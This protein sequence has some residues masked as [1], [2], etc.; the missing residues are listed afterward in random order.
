[1][2]EAIILGS[3]T[4]N[5]V[6][7]LGTTYTDEYLA[8]P[9]NHRTRASI[10]FKGPTGN[11]LVD[12]TPELRLQVT[13]QRITE[14]EA[15]VIT[16]AHAD[17]IMGMDDLRQISLRTHQAIPVYTLKEHAEDIR[18]IYSYAF[19]EF[20]PGISVPRFDL[21]E[22]PDVLHVGGLDFQ[23][24]LVD[25]GKTRVIGIRVN[26]FAYVTDVSFIPPAAEAMLHR[27]DVLILDAVR[28]APH[29]NHF[30]MEMAIEEAKKIGAKQTF[31]THLSDD[32]DHDKTNQTLP[33][34]IQ[35]AYDGMTFGI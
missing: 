26:N 13:G 7:T 6:P 3:G 35:L 33:E 18:R 11:L 12:C 25:H 23:T 2:S 4:S 14:I 10:L 22:V 15:V 16:H 29:P 24:F 19:K 21:R 30:N 1:V 34:N 31:F 20:P 32:F 5:G 28:Y 17:H 9:K 27:L 8:N